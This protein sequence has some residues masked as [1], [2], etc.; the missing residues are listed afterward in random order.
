MVACWVAGARVAGGVR[1]AGRGSPGGQQAAAAD[2]GAGAPTTQPHIQAPVAATSRCVT[3]S[4]T[5]LDVSCTYVAA[6]DDNDRARAAF[7][8][9]PLAPL[10]VKVLK[11]PNLVGLGMGGPAPGEGLAIEHEVG[12]K[13]LAIQPSPEASVPDARLAVGS[14][15]TMDALGGQSRAASDGQEHP[16][17]SVAG[18]QCEG[19]GPASSAKGTLQP[20]GQPVMDLSPPASVPEG[21]PPG[22]AQVSEGQNNA[23]TKP[24]PESAAERRSRLMLAASSAAEEAEAAQEP[25]KHGTRLADS[26]VEGMA[27]TNI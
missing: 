27:Q 10:Q 19:S 1:D 17:A 18:N 14:A 7:T 6:E 25:P 12:S 26:A 16:G 8:E 24:P 13:V 15:Q 11:G 21:S 3:A 2:L 5:F 22:G 9:A 23:L 20:E 4:S